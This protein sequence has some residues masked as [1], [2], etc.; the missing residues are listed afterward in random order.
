MTSASVLILC[1]GRGRRLG[2]LAEHMP[3]VL[4]PVNGRP[5]LSHVVE[6]FKGHG[7]E[8]FVLATG[9]LSEKVEDFARSSLAGCSVS[10][11]NAGAEASMLKR[12]HTARPYLA[13]EVIVGYGD[14]YID[15]DYRNF[16]EA[17]V[18]GGCPVTLVTG[19]IRNPFGVVT[20]GPSGKVTS[21]VEKPVYDYYIGCFA[22][23]RGLLDS[24]G[25]DLLARPDGE[26]LV[27]LFENLARSGELAAFPHE[28]LQLTFNT[29]EQLSAASALLREYFTMREK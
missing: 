20:L 2:P 9:H 1:G 12:I 26:G 21:F 7:F 17:H 16:L 6:Q 27:S 25:E 24:V 10:I 3:K 28:G 8:S 18:R 22:F 23:R 15:M 13:D 29:E 4:A 11:S 5:I 14:T 19:K